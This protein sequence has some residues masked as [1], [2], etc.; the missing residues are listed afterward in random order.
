MAWRVARYFVGSLVVLGVAAC[1][2]HWLAER[3]SWRHEA[4]LACLKSGQVKESR[5]LVRV[6][7]ITGPGVCGADFPLK[8]A[9]IGEGSAVGYADE[10]RPPGSIPGPRQ[11]LAYP[12]PAAPTYSPLPP[13]QFNPIRRSRLTHNSHTRRKPIRRKPIRRDPRACSRRTGRCRSMRPA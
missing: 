11:P 4:E 12:P 8:V 1:G 2:K 6:Q 13:P 3:E 7:P 9:A 5:A 10:L